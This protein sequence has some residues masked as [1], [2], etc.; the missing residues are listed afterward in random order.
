MIEVPGL[1]R[2]SL[3]LTSRHFKVNIKGPACPSSGGLYQSQAPYDSFGKVNGIE[4]FFGD[5]FA[6]FSGSGSP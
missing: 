1:A 6:S 3:R 2:N 4:N 5:F